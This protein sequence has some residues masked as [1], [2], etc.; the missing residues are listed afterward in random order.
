MTKIGPLE[1]QIHFFY[2]KKSKKDTK[3]LVEFY[4]KQTWNDSK[5][6]AFIFFKHGLYDNEPSPKGRTNQPPG[7]LWV[8]SA[9]VQ[10][11]VNISN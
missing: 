7:N 11:N 2:Y 10:C 5:P 8:F 1:A 9:I 3:K 4:F 6:L